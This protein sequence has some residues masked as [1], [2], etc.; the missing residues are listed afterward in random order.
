MNKFSFS[1]IKLISDPIRA[2]TINVGVLVETEHG[3]DIRLLKTEQKIKA[4][5]ENFN[6]SLIE[7][8]TSEIEWLY[9]LTPDIKTLSKLFKTGSIQLSEPGMFVLREQ[10]AYDK[11]VELLMKEYVQPCFS[12]ERTKQNKRIITELKQEFSR[13]GILGKTH[14]DLWNHRVV[15]NFP[16][17]ED[18]G[19]Y[20]ELLLKNGAY[21]LTETLDLRGDSTKQKMGDSALKAITISK[22]KNVFDGKVS[23]FV[24]YAANCLSE[25]KAGLR[26]LNLIE[27]YA[28]N[29]FNLLSEQDMAKYFDHMFTAAGKSLKFTN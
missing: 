28:D 2:E 29:V 3:L 12:S 16:I 20:A 8:F 26:Q 11:K 17:A 24:V 22:A 21:H 7:D 4:V 13:A 25:E 27:G 9:D 14:D 18:E 10:T 1:I 6:L 19:I 5:S 23:S 15:Y